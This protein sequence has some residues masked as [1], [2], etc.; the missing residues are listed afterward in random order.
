M[1]LPQD[2]REFLELLN[3]KKVEYIVVGGYAVAYH[4]FPRYTGDIDIWV[5]ISKD[6]AEKIILALKEFGFAS[7]QLSEEDFLQ[8]DIVVQ[9][10][11][12]PVRIDIMTSVTGLTFSEV[13]QKAEKIILDE[14]VVTMIDLESLKKNKLFTNRNKD[15][16][17]LENL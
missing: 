17:D 8:E 13:Y 1:K 14:V 11:Y 7:L 2:F 16:G 12:E 6:N 9:L 10:G 5:A 3:E 4:G 15:L